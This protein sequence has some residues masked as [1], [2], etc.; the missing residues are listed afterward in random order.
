MYLISSFSTQLIILQT[1]TLHGLYRIYNAMILIMACKLQVLTMQ[2]DFL[3][4]LYLGIILEYTFINCEP[5][6][7]YLSFS[8]YDTLTLH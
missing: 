6:E 1:L 4:I 7:G 8:S 5:R 2:Q 3:K